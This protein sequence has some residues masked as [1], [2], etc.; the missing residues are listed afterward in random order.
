[1]PPLDPQKTIAEMRAAYAASNTATTRNFLLMGDFGT[2]KSVTLSTL[3][4]PILYHTFDP[5]AVTSR[6]IKPKIDSGEIVVESFEAEDGKNPTEFERFDKR[7]DQLQ[8]G[9]IFTSGA[10]RSYAIDSLTTLADFVMN[11]IAKKAGRAGQVPQLQDYQMQQVIL[12]NIITRCTALP[13][14]FGVS[15]HIKSDKDEITGR[16]ITSLLVSGKL[17]VK[18][19]LLFD[20]V[21]VTRVTSDSKGA[22]YSLLT[23]SEGLYKARTRIGAGVFDL[24]EKPDLTYLLRKAGVLAE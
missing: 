3:P 8:A 22:T 4:P 7:M 15:G 20:E 14:F 13:L 6:L 9:G 1:M 24:S 16:I 23:G 21:Y 17:D 2:G 19:P 5:G 10:F 12:R 18:I 11:F